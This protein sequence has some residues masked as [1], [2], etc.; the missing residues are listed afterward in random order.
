MEQS[1]HIVV[2]GNEKF[3]V[4][5]NQ[6]YKVIGVMGYNFDCVL[7]GT[8]FLNANSTILSNEFYVDAN[9]SKN[10]HLFLKDFREKHHIKVVKFN[11]S[12]INKIIDIS[13]QQKILIPLLAL[14]IQLI[15]IMAIVYY[16]HNIKEEIYVKR[17]I[18]VDIISLLTENTKRL[19]IIFLASSILSLICSFALNYMILFK[20]GIQISVKNLMFI[21]SA[22][23][24][25]SFI[26]FYASLIIIYYKNKY[27]VWR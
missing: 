8:V 2:K 24:V 20:Y 10:I 4:L 21:F 19:C 18:G 11:G 15:L 22:I 7:N 17:I 6:H 27:K 5:N 26:I 13:V 14:F 12:I 9:T 1:K 16:L 25:E 3:F 23:I